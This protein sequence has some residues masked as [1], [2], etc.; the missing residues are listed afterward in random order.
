[1]QKAKGAINLNSTFLETSR[2]K[3][4]NLANGISSFQ[5]SV[6]TESIIDYV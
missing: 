2:P 1:M 4:T 3:K 6:T 5:V